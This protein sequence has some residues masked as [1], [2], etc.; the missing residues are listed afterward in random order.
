MLYLF[1]N[2]FLSLFPTAPVALL[3]SFFQRN[4]SSRVRATNVRVRVL[5]HLYLWPSEAHYSPPP[6]RR[7]EVTHTSVSEG[8]GEPTNANTGVCAGDP[9]CGPN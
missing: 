9:I 7:K 6:G 4:Q 2:L 5:S 1:T 3:F 8:G